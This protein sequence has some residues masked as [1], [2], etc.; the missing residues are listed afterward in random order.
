MAATFPSPERRDLDLRNR[1]VKTYR[2]TSKAGV[3]RIYDG[4]RLVTQAIG[5]RH[6]RGQLYPLNWRKRWEILQGNYK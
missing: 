2:G 4:L 1:I 5:F 3:N 6:L